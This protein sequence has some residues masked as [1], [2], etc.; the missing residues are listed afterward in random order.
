MIIPVI[1]KESLVQL[2]DVTRLD[3]SKTVL[4]K[5]S[6]GEIDSVLIRPGENSDFI[7]VFD[8]YQKN[9]Y[10]DVAF[11]DFYYDVVSGHNN[12]SGY[13]PDGTAFTYAVAPGTYDIDELV[14]AISSTLSTAL[15]AYPTTVFVDAR[16]RLN[17]ESTTLKF[18]SMRSPNNL[19]FHLG[20]SEVPANIG[21]PIE[22]FLRRITL[23]IETNGAGN[24]VDEEVKT[25]YYFIQIATEESDA[26]FSND[27]DLISFEP[28]IM[29]WL[30]NGRSSFLDLHRKSQKLIVDWVD[31]QGYR[32]I[33]NNKLTKWAFVDNADV[34]MW[35]VYLTLKLF[36]M[37]VQNA[38]DDVFKKKADYYHKLE[39]ESR[40]RALLSLDLDNDGE[41]D[42]SL[43]PDIRSGRLYFR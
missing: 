26:L 10:L 4:I 5:G 19:L 37:G 24:P 42:L 16:R 31:R 20:F 32:D 9:W 27:S 8:L 7:E 6:I 15:P 38:T 28:D 2:N 40:D 30:P 35:S 12:I 13:L 11:T 1:H 21:T 39:I 33:E 17:L 3:A 25:S 18:S 43:S 14:A 22:Y 41:K 29:K 23:T 36:F 34:R